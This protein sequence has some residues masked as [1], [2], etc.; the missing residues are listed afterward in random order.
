MARTPP[1]EKRDEAMWIGSGRPARMRFIIAQ[2]RPND[3][4]HTQ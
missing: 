4:R 3:N 1:A 2:Q